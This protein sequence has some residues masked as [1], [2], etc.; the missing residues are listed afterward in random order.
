MRALLIREIGKPAEFGE[1]VDP[2][3]SAG[4]SL[5]CVLAAPLNP[6][7]V[8]IVGGRFFGGHSALAYV[9]GAEAVGRVTQSNALPVGT[10]AFT[11]PDGSGISRSGA[12]AEFVVVRDCTP[13]RHAACATARWPTRRPR[14]PVG[15]PRW[16]DLGEHLPVPLAARPGDR[17][18]PHRLQQR[19][20]VGVGQLPLPV[21]GRESSLTSAHAT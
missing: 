20:V 15:E 6:V 17:V 8:S 5:L 21:L 1:V 19:E 2:V 13:Q 9:P 16:Q 14:R 10:I 4:E 18:L 3:P 11:C 12:C 7:D